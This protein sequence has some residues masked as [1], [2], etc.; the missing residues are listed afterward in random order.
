M[1]GFLLE[2]KNIKKRFYGIEA[3]GGV[4]F[5]VRKGE[6]HV[7]LG[8]NGA[9]KSTLMKILSGAYNS[10][11]GNIYWEGNLVSIRDPLNSLKLGIGMV[12]QEL[13]LI[14]NLSVFENIWLGQLPK[15]KY[16]PLVDWNAAR[17]KVEDIFRKLELSIDVR[18][19]VSKYDLG[20]QQLVEITRAISRDAKLVILDEPTSALTDT[21]VKKLFD[22]IKTLKK[23][24]VSFIYITHRLNEVF[25]VGDRVTV[26]RDGYTVGTVGD[27]DSVKEEDLV[28]MM[29]GRTIKEQYP[30]VCNIS[31]NEILRVKDLNDGRNFCDVSFTLHQGEVL[32]IAGLVGAGRTELAKAIFGLGKVKSGEIWVEGNGFVPKNPQ[33]AIRRSLGLL[34]KDRK[35]GLLLHMPI[36][37][38]ITVS[39]LTGFS[40][41]GFRRKKKEFMAA[42][43][44]IEMLKIDTVDTKK[45]VMHLSGGNQQ[46][47]AIAKWCCN[48]CK[49]FIMDDPTRGIDVGAK[50]EVY[51]LIN[52]ITAEGAGVILIS[53]DMPEL[54]GISD[55]ILVMKKGR[56][57]GNFSAEECNQELIVQKAAGGE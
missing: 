53:S 8:E 19:P 35:D 52:K 28:T 12:Y 9:G 14:K 22:T 26:L 13:S 48:K 46:K 56:I 17:R 21:E 5:N 32:G 18:M 33:N 23:Q 37:T 45:K 40:L 25:Q 11:E 43:D 41:L 4:D 20:I 31:T 44:F 34:T 30:K 6:V 49:I 24:G 1:E 38:N 57:V 27:I 51:K 3:L 54:L 16:L 47:V 7:L 36:F 2:M 29:V 55:N 39:S 10:D 50:V 15:R 42:V